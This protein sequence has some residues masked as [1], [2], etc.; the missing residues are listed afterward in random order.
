MNE[1]S[2][3]GRSKICPLSKIIVRET[4]GK[5]FYTE[6][7]TQHWV[8]VV[9]EK[10]VHLLDKRLAKGGE[11]VF[12]SGKA[13][14]VLPEGCLFQFL[15]DETKGCFVLEFSDQ[16]RKTMLHYLDLA[17]KDRR[18]LATF[19]GVSS[20]YDYDPPRYVPVQPRDF[21][22]A[23]EGTLWLHYRE[24]ELIPLWMDLSGK[25]SAGSRDD[26]KTLRVRAS[27]A[28]VF[29]PRW[30]TYLLY[31]SSSDSRWIAHPEA[32]GRIVCD[33]QTHKT[34]IVRDPG[35]MGYTGACFVA[36]DK[37]TNTPQFYSY[38]HYYLSVLEHIWDD[39]GKEDS[40][41]TFDEDDPIPYSKELV[42]E[43]VQM[44]KE[45][46]DEMDC[47]MEAIDFN[48]FEPIVDQDEGQGEWVVA[49]ARSRAS[50]PD[51][52]LYDLSD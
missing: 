33:F 13:H 40:M 1:W 30:R 2:G 37:T 3:S 48:N 8:I 14:I 38:T 21:V 51:W 6:R 44:N 28:R 20:D 34:Y 12:E 4:E 5:N 52:E 41:M 36:L 42:L 35:W 29:K 18:L 9:C 46:H 26:F 43:L 50:R 19:P 7:E 45:C 39:P 15:P 32:C 17:T 22:V 49:R 11:L 10:R 16:S 27:K 24:K 25:D 23:Y 47:E 31:Q